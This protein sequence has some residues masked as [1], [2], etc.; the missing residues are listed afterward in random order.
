MTIEKAKEIV[1][2]LEGTISRMKKNVVTESINPM[3]KAPR[4]KKS[5]L[6][7]KRNELKKKY[8]I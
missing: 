7:K 1:R 2:E 4:A 6:I 5:D 3:F 8:K